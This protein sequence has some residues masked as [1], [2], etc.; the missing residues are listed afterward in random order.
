MLKS[1]KSVSYRLLKTISRAGFYFFIAAEK[2]QIED[3]L[4]A[5]VSVK[6]AENDKYKKAIYA[7]K[8]SV[9]GLTSALTACKNTL[10]SAM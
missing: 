1:P 6:T 4:N 8:N 10:E 7:A 2:Q 3:E 9:G 5:D